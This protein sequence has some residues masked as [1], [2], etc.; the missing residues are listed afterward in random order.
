MQFFLS[1]RF[2]KFFD[3]FVNFANCQNA[4]E[5]IALVFLFDPVSDFC[6]WLGPYDFL[7][8]TGVQ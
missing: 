7:N 2:V 1:P 3:S 4:D 6:G 5:K 8:D